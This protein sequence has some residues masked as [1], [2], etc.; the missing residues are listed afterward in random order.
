MHH[1]NVPTYFTV[2]LE[3]VP[4]YDGAKIVRAFMETTP[5][6][7]NDMYEEM[8]SCHVCEEAHIEE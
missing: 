4:I 8:A 5:E 6:M 3:T 1:T 2:I 7:L